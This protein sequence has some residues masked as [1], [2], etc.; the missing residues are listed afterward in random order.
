MG[1]VRAGLKGQGANE[2]ATW[3]S[4]VGGYCLEPVPG[5]VPGF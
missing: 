4:V 3:W 5:S 1:K 2:A